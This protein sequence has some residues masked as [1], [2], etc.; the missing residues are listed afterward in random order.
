MFFKLSGGVLSTL[1]VLKTASG[2]PY[3][4]IF[5][6]QLLLNWCNDTS[7]NENKNRVTK[8]VSLLKLLHKL[9]S[10]LLHV[11]DLL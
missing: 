9:L 3:T 8:I 11:Q 1:C 5:T 4:V 7:N 10:N 2:W 6:P